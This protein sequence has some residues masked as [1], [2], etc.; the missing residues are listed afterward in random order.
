[1]NTEADVADRT[2]HSPAMATRLDRSA[3]AHRLLRIY[4]DDHWAAAGAGVALVRRVARENGDTE[5]GSRLDAVASEIAEDEKVLVRLRTTFGV[6]SRALV[7][8]GV[9]QTGER[10]A[11]LWPNGRLVHYSPLSRVLE[12]EALVAAANAKKQ[13][14]LALDRI[15][16]SGP[17][18]PEFS[19]LVTRADAQ[20]E[21]L[22]RF[23][24]SAV[25]RAFRS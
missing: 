7:R 6:T 9:A 18:Q 15:V 23:H 11:R 5:W 13:L 10:L 22:R 16:A 25:D 19:E 14:W 24:G 2:E 4:L 21:L 1:M 8:R 3:P 12:A 20:I 17:G